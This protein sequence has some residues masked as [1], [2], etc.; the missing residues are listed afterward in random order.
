MSLRRIA[1]LASSFFI[2]MRMN[3][4]LLRGIWKV[5][6]IPLPI[7]SIFGGSHLNLS[8]KY[9][10]QAHTIAEKLVARNISV[11]TGG[12]PGIMEAASCGAIAFGKAGVTSLGIGVTE[13]NE[14][15]NPCV[16]EYFEVKDFASRKWLL[17]RYA[18]G[19]VVFPGG[20]G[21]LDELAEI[22][23]LMQT[24]KLPRVPI[25]LIGKEYWH[26]FMHWLTKEALP[27]GVVTA[28]HLKLFSV[29]DNLDE[30]VNVI[31]SSCTIQKVK[32]GEIV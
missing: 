32:K 6:G 17:T 13:L 31:C 24:H 7:V 19:F 15:S 25:V 21:T 30:A 5:S 29:T 20:F 14:N 11:M 28:E 3:L 12:G 23:T 8:D 10:Q 27:H 26:F 16:Q 18:I 1:K 9:A 22:L 4:Q 2:L